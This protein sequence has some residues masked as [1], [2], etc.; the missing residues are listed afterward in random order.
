ML[1]ILMFLTATIPGI[2]LGVVE[3]RLQGTEPFL[4]EAYRVLAPGGTALI[5]VPYFHGLR[6]LKCRLGLYPGQT[7]GLYFYQYAFTS[8]EFTEI[9]T[10]FGFKVLKLFHYDPTKGF[11]AELPGLWRVAYWPYLGWLVTKVVGRLPYVRRY[12][13][14]MQLVVARKM[15]EAIHLGVP[16]N[17]G[18][19]AC[20]AGVRGQ[21]NQKGLS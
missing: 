8:E 14:H 16:L 2:S 17:R 9:L 1:H 18:F 3:Q 19:E 5:S 12:F 7:S 20:L 6:R 4:E 11:L 13:G 21:E 15:R 10:N